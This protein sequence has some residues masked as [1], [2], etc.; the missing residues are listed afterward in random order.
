MFHYHWIYFA[1]PRIKCH[2]ISPIL[3]ILKNDYTTNFNI[4]FLR[5]FIFLKSFRRLPFAGFFN[6]HNW[7]QNFLLINHLL[8]S[9]KFRYLYISIEHGAIFFTNL[10]YLINIKTLEQNISSCSSGK[11]EKCQRNLRIIENILK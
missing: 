10:K 2:C 3:L 9:F 6:I 7:K 8:L 5:V 11:K 4:L 1:N